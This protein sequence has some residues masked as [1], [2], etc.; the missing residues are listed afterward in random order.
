MVG[1][2]WRRSEV[3]PEG[4]PACSPGREP[5]VSGAHFLRAPEGRQQ[6][7]QYLYGGIATL[8]A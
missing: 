5:R 7:S 6:T 8:R 4:A 1:D 3:P 2:A